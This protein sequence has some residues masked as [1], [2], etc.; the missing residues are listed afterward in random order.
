MIFTQTVAEMAAE[1]EAVASG[2][3]IAGGHVPITAADRAARKAS[4]ARFEEEDALLLPNGH[5]KPPES[6]QAQAMPS[7]GAD[8]S[9]KELPEIDATGLRVRRSSRSSPVPIVE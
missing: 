1:A 7:V 9:R 6:P 5:A 3:P 8:A 4:A 2:V